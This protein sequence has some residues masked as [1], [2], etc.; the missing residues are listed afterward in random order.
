MFKLFTRMLNKFKF[1]KPS[2]AFRIV[3]IK[4]QPSDKNVCVTYQVCGKSAVITEKP[5]KLVEHLMQLKGFSK[6]DSQVVYDLAVIER[7][8]PTLKIFNM[9]F[10]NDLVL[11]EIIDLEHKYK[12]RLTSEEILESTNLITCFSPDDIMRI[13]LQH[14]HNQQ[15]LEKIQL[16]QLS[17]ATSTP[18]IYHF[19]G[20]KTK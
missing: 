9:L 6:Q 19:N 13:H 4:G 16:K 5:H 14:M 1:A 15:R 17:R 2:Y 18:N 3:A 10:D 11:F 12:L 20:S 7:I 8:N